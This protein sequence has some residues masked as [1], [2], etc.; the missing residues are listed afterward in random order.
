MQPTVCVLTGDVNLS[1][2]AAN[3]AAQPD[4]GEP[5]LLNHWHT[6][7]SNAAKSGDV[8][9]V[10]GAASKSWD[11]SIGSS[12][13]GRGMSRGQHDIGMA[14]EVPLVQESP[15]SSML[16]PRPTPASPSASSGAPHPVASGGSAS[17][18][19][20]Q[21]VAAEN[22]PSLVMDLTEDRT[23]DEGMAAASRDAGTAQSRTADTG[24]VDEATV[25]TSSGVPQ[26]AA[27][28]STEGPI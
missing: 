16:P 26:P 2:D 1:R 8:V 10:K 17:S 13:N 28:N 19:A 21:P 11:V 20:P 23:T 12:Y 22:P 18:A 27:A 7:A 3:A 4:V 15:P 9:F 5:D 24:T 25:G 6:E 14:L